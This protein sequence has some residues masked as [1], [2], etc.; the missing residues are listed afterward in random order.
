MLEQCIDA[1]YYPAT[2][3]VTDVRFDPVRG[4][5]DFRSLVRRADEMH[6]LAL[7]SF[8][9]ADGPRLLGMAGV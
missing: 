2:T 1:G 3:L 4:S 5:S 7:E 6:R 9:A 8:R